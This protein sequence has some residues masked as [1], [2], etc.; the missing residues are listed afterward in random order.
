MLDF[1]I[2]SADSHSNEPESLYDRLPTEYRSRAPHEAVVNGQRCLIYEGQP[3]VPME[4]PNPL[5]EDDMNR[6][7]RVEGEELGRVQH[8]AG[9]V[10]VNLRM[11]DLERDGVSAEVIYPQAVFKL[12]SS[13]D[14]GYQLALAQLYNDWHDEI[15]G[16]SPDTFVVSAQIPV[17]DIEDGI[18]EAKR[19][20]DM[21]YR[22]FSLPVVMPTV[23]YNRPEYEPFWA[24][25]QDTGVPLA[26]HVF[27]GGPTGQSPSKVPYKT[28][29]GSDYLGQVLGMTHA[30][31][32][33]VQLITSG[34][35]AKYP[36]LKFVLVESGI[37]W[38]A[39]LLYQMDDNHHRRHMWEVP[40]LEMLPSEYFKRQGFATF[41]DDLP[42]LLAREI[43]GVECLMW[44]SDYP[45]DEGTFPHS[46]EVID[47]IFK[48][49][50]EDETRKI[51]R[52]NAAKLYNF[53]LN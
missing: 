29:A 41:G 52:D 38:L 31:F 46:R 17:I 28:E 34:A 49:I 3:P 5:N 44:G 10:D 1:P 27:T 9:G 32:P 43:T 7:W 14:P 11:A 8:R 18:S 23:P 33:M 24:A 37:G 51:V 6:Y 25:V 39:W 53:P 42:G 22:S 48:G 30:M 50:P 13:P 20:A 12:F 4:A 16:G 35:C 40:R 47:R 2:I 15:F 45:H 19:A 21:G 26:F 36:D